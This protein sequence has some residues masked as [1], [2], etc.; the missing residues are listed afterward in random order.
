MVLSTLLAISR[1]LRYS[2]SYTND[3]WEYLRLGHAI[4]QGTFFAADNGFRT[5]LFPLYLALAGNNPQLVFVG[6]LALGI[7]TSLLIFHIFSQITGRPPLGVAVAALYNLNPSTA[8]FETRVLTET[9][10]TFFVTLG[11]FFAVRACCDRSRFVREMISSGSAF[12]LASLTRP[13]YHLLPLIAAVVVAILATRSEREPQ[14]RRRTLQGVAGGLIP[15]VV[16]V[17]GWSTVNYVRFGWFTV[18]TLTGYHLTQYSGPYLKDAPVQYKKLTD[19]YLRYQEVQVRETGRH[20]DTFW[21]ARPELLKATSMTDAQISRLFIR[22]SLPILVAHPSGYL[23][24]VARSLR[25]FWRP[26]V[27]ARACNLGDLRQALRG[28]LRGR[29]WWWDRLFA[30][31]Y[32]PFDLAYGLA[33]IGPL[34][35]QRWR[36]LLWSPGMLV[37]NTVVL[38]TALITS[39]IEPEDNNRFKMPVESLILGGAVTVFYLVS[40]DLSGWRRRG[41][42]REA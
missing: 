22:I 33:V 40:S 1:W 16:L 19:I 41:L 12:S 20:L 17:L 5:P 13:E 10:T 25:V 38:Y 26:P 32:L 30:Y 24:P 18:S 9:L 37:V 29:A 35:V 8:L 2:P 23:A 27:Y 11:T 28:V 15:F 34:F 6:H 7:L 14:A 42:P 3:S 4:S 39:L 31:A 21:Q 36:W